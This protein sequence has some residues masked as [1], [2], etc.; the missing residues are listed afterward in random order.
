MIATRRTL[1]KRLVSLRNRYAGVPLEE[2][3]GVLAKINE[4]Q[5]ALAEGGPRYVP[6]EPEEFKPYDL[7]LLHGGFPV[8]VNVV[9]EFKQ[10]IGSRTHR[11]AVAQLGHSARALA[12]T[13]DPPRFL[14]AFHPLKREPL[15]L[16]G[17][18]YVA[19]LVERIGAA[20]FAEVLD[21][22]SPVQTI[23]S[24]GRSL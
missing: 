18:G 15:A 24:E 10:T 23:N 7:E 11:F 14:G 2:Q 1:Q 17:A 16:Q 6:V 12:V 19:S 20:R 3:P 5:A 4:I 22:P 21:G 13:L 8:T 9:A